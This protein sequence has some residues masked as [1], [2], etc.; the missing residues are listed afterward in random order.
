L[1]SAN[2]RPQDGLRGVSNSHRNIEARLLG[3]T[4]LTTCPLCD[5]PFADEEQARRI[6]ARWEDHQ[7]ELAEEIQ[8]KARKDGIEAGRASAQED[9]NALIT[10]NA[11]AAEQLVAAVIRA[12]N[13][14][15]NMDAVVNQRVGEGVEAY[16][17]QTEA[18]YA[19]E[20]LVRIQ[21]NQKLNE[22]VAKLQRDLAN[23]KPT[24]LG[25]SAQRD[26][27]RDL[28]AAFPQDK[29]TEVAKGTKGGDLPHFV[30]HKGMRSVAFSTRSRTSKIGVTVTRSRRGP[31][32][33][34]E[35]SIMPW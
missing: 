4:A 3:E 33:W 23:R 2:I 19:A 16:R 27:H 13:L 24:D 7:R 10:K 8:A 21:E 25:D 29:I 32:K 15:A 20:A 26:T 12:D 14:E 18:K 28:T 11:A 30:N 31:I 9:I 6:H 22:H 34:R 35:S 1:S 17:Q 5:R